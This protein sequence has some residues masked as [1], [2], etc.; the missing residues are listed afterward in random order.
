MKSSSNE[1][2]EMPTPSLTTRR[3]PTVRPVVFL[4]FGQPVPGDRSSGQL[5]EAEVE[6]TS[7]RA[8]QEA[9]AAGYAEGYARGQIEGKR[10]YQEHVD[11]LALLATQAS[12]DLQTTLHELEPEIV[13]LALTIAN[14]I[15]EREFTLD[16]E[17]VV[18][19][20]RSAI[21]A[22]GQLLVVRVRVHPD[23]YD[24]VARAWSSLTPARKD[25]AA[26]LVAD[27]KVEFGGCVVDTTTGFVDA[28]R[29]TRFDEMRKQLFS[30][31]GGDW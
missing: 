8:R 13:E 21:E 14:R 11:R 17:L 16:R 4:A 23:D 2:G 18:N 22:V 24:I 30:M 6:A 28:Q 19:T 15:V 10:L 25:L 5:T 1:A 31:V 27:P 12:H 7:E 20:V 26:E 9:A 29:N 3:E